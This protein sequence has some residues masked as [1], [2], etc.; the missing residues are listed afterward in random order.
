MLALP[1]EP[2]AHELF[3]SRGQAGAIIEIPGFAQR[4]SLGRVGEN[5][6][7]QFAQAQAVRHG[8]GIDGNHIPGVAGHDRRSQDFIS[9]LVHMD[10]GKSLCLAIEDSPVDIME[11]LYKRVNGRAG[12]GGSRLGDTDMGNLWLGI[13][14]PGDS[15]RRGFLPPLEQGISNHRTGQKISRM[16]ELVARTD[17]A[18]RKNTGIGSAQILV[19]LYSTGIVGHASVLQAEPFHYRGLFSE[20]SIATA[21]GQKAL[22]LLNFD[23]RTKMP[24]RFHTAQDTVANLDPA[25]LARSEQFLWALLQQMDAG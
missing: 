14:R 2:P 6:F 13:G 18:G 3:D 9:A 7:C 8:H 24:P 4:L 16:G 25:L 19:D 17:I 11:R 15:K 23:P 20:M 22:G 10:L 21:H 1:G 12:L 5:D